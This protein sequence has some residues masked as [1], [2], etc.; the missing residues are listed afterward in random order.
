MVS[1][2]MSIIN[3]YMIKALQVQNLEL[4]SELPV[5]TYFAQFPCGDLYTV[6]NLNLCYKFMN[7]HSVDSYQKSNE[8]KCMDQLP[9]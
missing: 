6:I 1:L 3:P 8:M 7:H 4:V 2:F 9:N 5:L